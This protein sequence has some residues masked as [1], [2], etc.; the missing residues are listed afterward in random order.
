MQ[1]IKQ[2]VL[3]LAMGVAALTNAQNV[4]E[5]STTMSLGPQNAYY[6]EVEGA[7]KNM[8][9]E[10]MQEK[11]KEYGKIKENKKA[12]EYFLMATKVPLINGTS[13]LDIYTKYTEGKGQS[14][15]YMWVD[16]GGA[17]ATTPNNPS[18][19]E[20]IRQFMIDYH[21]AVRK[22]VVT[23]ELKAEEKNLSNLEKDLEKLKSKHEDYLSDIEK[24]KQKISDAET[25]IVKNNNEQENKNKEILTQKD[26]VAKVV[27]RFNA[28]GKQN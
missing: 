11:L 19:S 7:D 4:V 6:V 10:T 12:K 21:N 16:L 15:A 23:K 24:A 25:N 27:D 14:T 2:V 18:Q 3:T 5:K 9:E 28:I 1:T 8:L 20:G 26:N 17:F 22:K 13:P